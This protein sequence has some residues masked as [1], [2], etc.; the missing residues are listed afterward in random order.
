MRKKKTIAF[1]LGLRLG[2]TLSQDNLVL[3]FSQ[4]VQNL[5]IKGVTMKEGGKEDV[6]SA[7]DG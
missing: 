1:G 7:L 2:S 3:F 4:Q 6:P 5:R